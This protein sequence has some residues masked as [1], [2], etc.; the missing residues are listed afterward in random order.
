MVTLEANT[1]QVET[2]NAVVQA[3]AKDCLF[4]RY[5]KPRLIPEFTSNEHLVLEPGNF[6]D[7]LVASLPGNDDQYLI[8][9]PRVEPIR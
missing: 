9:T 5:D 7:D 2:L 8:R 6:I 3:Y 1:D 4:Y